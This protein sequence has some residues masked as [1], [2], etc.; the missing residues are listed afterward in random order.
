MEECHQTARG[1][2]G[3][4]EYGL[5]K[6]ESIK[7]KPTEEARVLSFPLSLKMKTKLAEM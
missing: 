7:K 1:W 2:S 4:R 5:L 6:R 3:L